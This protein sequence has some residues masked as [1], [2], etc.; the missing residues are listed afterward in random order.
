MGK[1]PVIFRKRFSVL[2]L[3]VA[4]ILTVLSQ[5]GMGATVSARS[6]TGTKSRSRKVSEAPHARKRLTRLSRSRAHTV[7]VAATVRRHRRHYYEHFTASSFMD[8]SFESDVTAGEDPVVRQAA[9]DALGNMNGTVLAI[10][11][12]SGRVWP[13]LTKNWHFR[14]AHSPARPSNC[15]WRWPRSAKT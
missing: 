15:P 6:L 1:E 7:R 9:I 3:L 11:P 13:W 5:D 4:F 2:G 14:A 12:T 8:D 10:E